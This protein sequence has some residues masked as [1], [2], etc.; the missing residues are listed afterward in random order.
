MVERATPGK[1]RRSQHREERRGLAKKP[2]RAA[3]VDVHVH[4]PSAFA[5]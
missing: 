5:N 1:Q 4:A 3:E 2:C